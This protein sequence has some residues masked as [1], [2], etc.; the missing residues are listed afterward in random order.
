MTRAL[1]VLALVV[2]VLG[3][4]ALM[5]RGWRRRALRHPGVDPAPA[6]PADPG[7]AL[8]PTAEGVYVATTT[9]GDWLDRVTARGLGAR[10]AADMLVTAA[11]VGWRR[12]GA[13]DL[14]VPAADLVA[15]RRS[16]GMAGKFVER[17]GLVV[18][19]WRSGD[20]ALDTGFRPRHGDD[21]ARL[22]DAVGTLIDD[23]ST[24]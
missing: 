18:V 1:S 21:T 20:R 24:R 12:R 2:L 7:P 15:V 6:L 19:T 8:T 3:V 23:G 16:D 11:G 22:T 17:G 14:W 9:E 5:L 13:P 4:W 10:S